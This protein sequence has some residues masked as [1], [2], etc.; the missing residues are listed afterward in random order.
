MREVLL[1]NDNVETVKSI[2]ER[3][4]QLRGDHDEL[5]RRGAAYAKEVGELLNKAKPIVGGM[6]G[7][8]LAKELDMTTECA[9]KYTTIASGWKNIQKHEMF[10]G[11]SV[12]EM[13]DIARGGEPRKRS[14]KLMGRR[15]DTLIAILDERLSAVVDQYPELEKL[16]DAIDRARPVLEAAGLLRDGVEARK[17]SLIIQRA[18]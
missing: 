5:L 9:R 8:W 17:R 3:I 13:Y 16:I 12:V 6:W 18:G 15:L 1:K 4:R 14:Y 11:L 2:A 10:P 7:K